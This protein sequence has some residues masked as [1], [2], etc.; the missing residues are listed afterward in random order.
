MGKVNLMLLS[1]IISLIP[2]IGL[3][4]CLVWGCI[5][6]EPTTI[7]H[8]GHRIFN[9]NYL[10]YLETERRDNWQK[11]VEVLNALEISNKAV[12]ADI[13]A[14]GGYFTEKFSKYLDLSGHVYAT[15]VQDV[16]LEK[17]K[18]RVAKRQLNNVEVIRGEFD[19]PMLP[20]AS[21]DLVFFSSVYKEI[22][23]RIDYMKKIKTALK[24]GGRVAIIE[25]LPGLMT[26][27]PPMEMR[28]QPEQVIQELSAA[29]FTLVKSYDF[30]PREYFL[31][32]ALT[33]HN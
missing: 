19:D 4:I 26:P 18:E 15:D 10:F 1:S 22:D 3:A 2:R 24:P 16:M 23:G 32:F 30:L 14:G 9:A 6:C 33:D 29:G 17:L 7:D 28:L 27:G 13:G 5:S 12:V 25:F 21:C 20:E 31:I 8:Q 11:P